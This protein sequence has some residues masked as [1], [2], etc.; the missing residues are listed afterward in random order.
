MGQC[1]LGHLSWIS[2]PVSCANRALRS[3]SRISP[4]KSSKFCCSARVRSSPAKNCSRRFHPEFKSLAPDGSPCKADTRGLLK[5]CP[6]TAAGFH[7]IGKETERGWDQVDDVSTLL[8]ELVR[9]DAAGKTASIRLQQKLQQI[10]IAQRSEAAHEIAAAPA[11]CIPVLDPRH[12]SQKCHPPL[13]NPSAP[14]HNSRQL[15]EPA[16]HNI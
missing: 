1:A 5:R 12:D 8:P 16:V 6:V 4:A 3:N 11:D 14:E 15:G 7:F 2:G 13:T 10:P 9:Y